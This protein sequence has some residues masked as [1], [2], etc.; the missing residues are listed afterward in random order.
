MLHTYVWFIWCRGLALHIHAIIVYRIPKRYIYDTRSIFNKFKFC[1]SLSSRSSSTTQ[2]CAV[3]GDTPPS[4]YTYTPF[5]GIWWCCRNIVSLDIAYYIYRCWIFARTLKC[6]QTPP[7]PP[8][9][10]IFMGNILWAEYFIN[11]F[12][13]RSFAYSP[14]YSDR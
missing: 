3:C 6:E 7:P 2:W 12:R 4:I 8:M 1:A 9:T 11:I 14:I 10:C 13:G 5:V